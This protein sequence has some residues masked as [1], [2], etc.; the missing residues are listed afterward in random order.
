MKRTV[1]VLSLLVVIVPSGVPA[2]DADAEP[3]SMG[4]HVTC[5][6]L[7]RILAGG[8][9]QKDRTS[10]ADFRAI[11]DWYKERAFEEI[12]AAKRAATELYGDELAFEL[13]DEEWQTVYGD[14]MNQIGNNYRN[15][16]RLRYRY[17]DRCDIKPKFD[18]N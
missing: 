17:G 1:L 6:V 15:L 14:M 12:A 7:F 5:G 3:R 8:M 9:L 2:S 4:E 13:F 11:A 18:A 10:T 16:S